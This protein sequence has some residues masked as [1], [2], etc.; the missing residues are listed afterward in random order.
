M[1]ELNFE[2]FSEHNG[3]TNLRKNTDKS[4]RARSLKKKDLIYKC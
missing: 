3:I 4:N 1:H 2:D